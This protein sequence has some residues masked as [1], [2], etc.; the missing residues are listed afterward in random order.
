MRTSSKAA[1]IGAAAGFAFA[2]LSL[3][4]PHLPDQPVR[5]PEQVREQR[6]Q[7]D[8][9]DL[10]DAD[11]NQKARMRDEGNDLVDHLEEERLRPGEHRPP[12]GPKPPRL[13]FIIK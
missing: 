7:Q 2:T 1:V 3:V 10:G 13:R 6:M 4:E 11:G 9:E 5:T 12:E 8:L